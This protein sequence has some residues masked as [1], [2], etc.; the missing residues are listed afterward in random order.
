MN[1]VKLSSIM[2]ILMVFVTCLNVWAQNK[3]IDYL[4]YKWEDKP[5]YKA[6]IEKEDFSEIVIKDKTAV[7][8]VL[9]KGSF[10]Q[11]DFEHKIIYIAGELGVEENNKIYLSTYDFEEVIFQKARVIN[12]AGQIIEF[13]KKDIKEAV[14]EQSGY[15]FQYFALDGLDIGSFVE[16]IFLTKKPAKYSGAQ[17]TLQSTV[18]KKNVEFELI[19]PDN[20]LFAFLSTNGMEAVQ[21]DTTLND[22]N[23]YRLS[24]SKMEE[25][26]Y[27]PISY[28]DANL[29]SVVYKLDANTASGATDMTTYA[30]VANNYCSY[31]Y[32]DFSKSDEKSD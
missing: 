9:E 24:I 3:S 21:L 13:N 16:T 25:H 11:Y 23:Y 14:D 27:E 4:D 8:Y 1:K 29:K 7:E 28:G 19:C 22:K 18:P 31:M 10:L 2:T 32:D 12:A 6:P 26:E 20:L 30:T 17:K 5:S 15:S